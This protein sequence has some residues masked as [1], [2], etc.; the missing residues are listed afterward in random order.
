MKQKELN[1]KSDKDLL[2]L[3]KNLE[4]N[5]IKASSSGSELVK[6]KE[7][8]IISKKGITQKGTR[9]SL[10]KQLRRIIAQV[11]TLL[12]QRGLLQELNT[13]KYKSKRRKRRLRGRIK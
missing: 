10:K 1:K 8:G 12:N 5:L 11:N 4:M 2:K 13:R 9:T 6:N 3:K 7:A